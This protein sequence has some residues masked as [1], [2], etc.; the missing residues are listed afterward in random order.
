MKKLLAL[1]TVLIA[2]LLA[3][4]AVAEEAPAPEPTQAE[5]Q[6]DEAVDQ[7]AAESCMT[8]AENPLQIESP[9]DVPV[10]NV[11]SCKDLCKRDQ[12]CGEG[13]VCLPAGPCGCK[14]C[15]YSS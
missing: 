12:H 7:V 9:M 3:G 2:C 15:F 5:A 6:A 14:Q 13:G 11:C 10:Q 4:P 8:V 1:A